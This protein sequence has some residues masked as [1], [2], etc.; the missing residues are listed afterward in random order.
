VVTALLLAGG[1]GCA[2]PERPA[3]TPAA[4]AVPAPP[5]TAVAGK[6]SPA[7]VVL[8]PHLQ[9]GPP[10]ELTV[11][12]V[13]GG[14]LETAR[15][16]T[17]KKPLTRD[18]LVHADLAARQVIASRILA[19]DPR[20]AGLRS[21]YLREALPKIAAAGFIREHALLDF[22]GSAGGAVDPLP[23][24]RVT[25]YRSWLVQQDLHLVPETWAALRVDGV[26][27]RRA[28]R[29]DGPMATTR[30]QAARPAQ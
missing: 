14:F 30:L 13:Y 2:R 10:A 15:T 19:N 16:F 21:R 7:R 8:S 28:P 18:W 24:E 11:W 12:L 25:S 4:D 3:A 17:M 6:T 23:L 27:L 29:P 26:L 1:A 5:A 9:S 20:F 22:S